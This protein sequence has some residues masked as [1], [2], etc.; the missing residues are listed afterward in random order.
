MK[1][2]KRID[3][4]YVL[5]MVNV[6]LAILLLME[7]VMPVFGFFAAKKEGFSAEAALRKELGPGPFVITSSQVLDQT[8]DDS[9]NI[10]FILGDATKFMTDS[11][12]VNSSTHM[13][14]ISIRE[15]GIPLQDDRGHSKVHELPRGPL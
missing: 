8:G 14:P 6:L 12:D 9:D 13:C 2:V 5:I 10:P 11:Q 4:Y 15:R 1:G 7:S 3:I